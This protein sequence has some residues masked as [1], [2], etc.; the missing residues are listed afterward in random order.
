VD[1][2]ELAVYLHGQRA[3]SHSKHLIYVAGLQRAN[4]FECMVFALLSRPL[5]FF[6]SYEHL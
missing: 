5:L 1:N 2:R 6:T 3:R 4:I